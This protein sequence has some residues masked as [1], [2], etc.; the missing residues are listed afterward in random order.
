MNWN[1]RR[2]FPE[3][4]M[5]LVMSIASMFLVG[6]IANACSDSVGPESIVGLWDLTGS[7][8][9][10]SQE[11]LLALDGSTVSGHGNWCGEALRCGT[12]T[13][14]G[15]ATGNKIH[16]VTTFDDGRLVSFDGR[17]ISANSLIG[18]A[19]STSP[20]DVL[21]SPQSFRRQMGDPPTAQ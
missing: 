21:S 13:V 12:T 14:S 19:V 17:L 2:T 8:P 5:R 9:G 10:N 1:T 15:T 11:M 18:R 7:L 16:L 4:F 20:P 3:V 6:G